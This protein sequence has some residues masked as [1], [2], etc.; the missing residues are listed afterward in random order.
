MVECL[1]IGAGLDFHDG[2]SENQHDEGKKHAK[3][4]E[5]PALAAG[6]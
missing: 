6:V 4:A 5:V 3:N 2:Q 1:G